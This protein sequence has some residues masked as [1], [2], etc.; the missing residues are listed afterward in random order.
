MDRLKYKSVIYAEMD[1]FKQGSCA[2]NEYEIP[3]IR[4]ER[5]ECVAKDY[6]DNIVSF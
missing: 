2:G 5:S 3:I 1:G 4:E 6:A